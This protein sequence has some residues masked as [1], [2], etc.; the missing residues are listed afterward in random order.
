LRLDPRIKDDQLQRAVLEME[1]E[2]QNP[3]QKAKPIDQ[4]ALN[5]EE[6]YFAKNATKGGNKP[7]EID[8]S[9][10]KRKK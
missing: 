3:K 10:F 2:Q 4:D 9:Q 8:F 1:E 5:E 7:E 6:S